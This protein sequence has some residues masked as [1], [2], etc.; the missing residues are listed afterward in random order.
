MGFALGTGCW[1]I[2]LRL[3][4]ARLALPG[5]LEAVSLSLLFTVIAWPP[6]FATIATIVPSAL[7]VLVF[8]R[9]Q[10]AVSRMLCTGP[11]VWLGQVSYALYMVHAMV[12]GRAI[13]A[14]MLLGTWNGTPLAEWAMDDETPVKR[15]ILAPLPSTLM[16][17]AIIAAMLLAAHLAH[18]WI[19][20]PARQWSR[21]LAT[22]L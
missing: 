22:R 13:D 15:L 10:G 5:L 18:V 3:G 19:E 8:A 17:L 2:H 4:A 14:L 21:R 12:K 11:W 20:E 16:Q 1:L 9:Q 7:V 6:P